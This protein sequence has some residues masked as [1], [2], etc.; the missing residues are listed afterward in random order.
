MSKTIAALYD[1]LATAHDVVF[2]LSNSTYFPAEDISIISHDTDSRYSRYIKELEIDDSQRSAVGTGAGAGATAGTVVGAL[3]GVLLGTS[4]L[5]IPGVGPILALGPVGT[6]LVSAGAGALL[7]GLT[8]A[9]VGMGIDDS[10]AKLYTEAVRRG[11]TLVLLRS[12]DAYVKKAIQLME[13]GDPIDIEQRA[14]DWR[15]DGWV[16]ERIT[17]EVDPTPN[18]LPTT[19]GNALTRATTEDAHTRLDGKKYDPEQDGPKRVAEP[20]D[21]STPRSLELRD[22]LPEADG[23]PT[24]HRSVRTYDY[25]LTTIPPTLEHDFR[26]HLHEHPPTHDATPRYEDYEDAYALGAWL[27]RYEKMQW[28]Q[29]QAQAHRLWAEQHSDRDETWDEVKERVQY[30]WHKAK[31]DLYRSTL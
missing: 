10:D 4:V 8:G 16:H 30:A 6:A 21:Y 9:L 11:A 3:V 13:Q 24:P 28:E 26:L 2:S 18:M 31:A 7:G 17:G 25:L 23:D 14:A 20:A 27:G 15:A 29:L 1:D 12:P 22:A 19:G 5:L